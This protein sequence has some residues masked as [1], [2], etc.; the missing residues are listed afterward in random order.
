MLEHEDQINAMHDDLKKNHVKRLND[1]THRLNAGFIF[2]ELID[3]LERIGDRLTNIAQ[4]V[5][6][7]M[8]WMPTKLEREKTFV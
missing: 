4:S 5:I 7:K 2:L 6:G 8:E 1:G 3:N